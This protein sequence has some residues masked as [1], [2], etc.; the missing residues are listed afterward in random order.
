MTARTTSADYVVMND[1][2]ATTDLSQYAFPGTVTGETRTQ[3]GA[4]KWDQNGDLWTKSDLG[5]KPV[6]EVVGLII[7]SD[8]WPSISVNDTLYFGDVVY[9][10]GIPYTQSVTPNGVA[11]GETTTHA[12]GLKTPLTPGLYVL[13]VNV[14]MPP[15]GYD[16]DTDYTATLTVDD[17]PVDVLNPLVETKDIK[18][19]HNNNNEA[20]LS[21]TLTYVVPDG[22]TTEYGIRFSISPEAPTLPGRLRMSLIKISD[23]DSNEITS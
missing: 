6:H 5:W 8:S 20:M 16:V 19:F 18:S 13:T 9:S 10:N 23:I 12:R 14:T 4:I 17:D 3:N 11:E 22:E 7:K 1:Q 15:L 2:T 21:T